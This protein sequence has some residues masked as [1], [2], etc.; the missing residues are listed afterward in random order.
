MLKIDIGFGSIPS[1]FLTI[2]F[3][4]RERGTFLIN[5]QGRYYSQFQ[6]TDRSSWFHITP[7][8]DENFTSEEKDRFSITNVFYLFFFVVVFFK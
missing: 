2:E 7:K 8:I 1:F 4:G 6:C 5:H 3:L